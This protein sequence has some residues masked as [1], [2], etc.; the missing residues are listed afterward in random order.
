VEAVHQRREHARAEI[1]RFELEPDAEALRALARAIEDQDAAAQRLAEHERRLA[2]A[3]TR[4]AESSRG[5]S[6]ALG[7]DA[8]EDAELARRAF[9][10]YQRECEER[11]RVAREADRRADLERALDERRQREDDFARAREVWLAGA[12]AL[13]AE[14]AALGLT[15][16]DGQD[17]LALL[18]QW[19]QAQR[20]LASR[21]AEADTLD[22]K[23]GQLLDGST[24]E[25]L[26]AER[27]ERAGAAG[28][29]PDPLRPVT[30]DQRRGAE[31]HR[32]DLRAARATTLGQLRETEKALSPIPEAIEAE[33]QAEAA[34]RVVRQLD[35]TLALAQQH[36]EIAKDRAHADI[37]PV[38]AGT[39]RPW[40]PQV[41]G[42]RFVD[43]EIDAGTLMVRAVES[44]G[45]P[46]DADV[47]SHGTME[48]L[49]LLLRIALASHLATT[50]ETAPLILDDIT[51]QSDRDRTL[52]ILELLQELSATRQVVLFTQEVEVIEWAQAH[53]EPNEVIAL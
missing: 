11:D 53:L 4:F 3:T 15:N 20:R 39:I 13:R 49:F 31:S 28:E 26:H 32:D 45:R 43:V 16:E 5:L 14:S 37:A 7:Q 9:E 10:E 36:L 51:V 46:R 12:A 2:E 29:R 34:S 44:G 30:E 27:D 22:A 35:R 19:L 23:L 52:A 33:A 6:A 18:D 48:Q 40:V 41:T 47:L 1:E 25:Q 24:I 21:R 38:L 17:P 42:G 8:T 50:D